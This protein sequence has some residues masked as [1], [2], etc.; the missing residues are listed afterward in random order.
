MKHI[1]LPALDEAQTRVVTRE[2]LEVEDVPSGLRL[3]HSPALVDGI[4]GGDVITLEPESLQG[5]KVVSR[6]GNL[7]VVT[8]FPTTELRAQAEPELSIDVRAIGG[9]CDG[10][11][12]R[13][14]VFTVPVSTGFSTVEELFN[15]VPS[16]WPATVWYFGNVYAADQTPI[17]WW[18]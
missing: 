1:L 15:T 16:R 4:A 2:M 5:F 7:A 6:G 13:M 17:N 12:P 3:L 9:V 18:L 10:G 8:V 11:P 14:L